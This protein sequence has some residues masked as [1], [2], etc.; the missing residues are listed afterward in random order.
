M[1]HL[2]R[3]AIFFYLLVIFVVGFT[4]LLVLA[5]AVDFKH[6]QD[7]LKFVYLDPKA[8]TIAGLVVAATMLIGFAFA[9]IIYG[10]QAQERIIHFD[11]PLGRVSISLSALEDMIRRLTVNT[12]QVKEIRPE[13]AANKKGLNIHIRLVLRSDVNIPEMTA[14][15]QD[16][17]RRKVQDLIGSEERVHIRVHVIKI[18]SDG[19]KES[20]E[21]EVVSP[22]PFRGYRA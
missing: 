13:I 16:I 12:P 8:G 17:I 10:R 2:I 22:V 5:H 14:D 19:V 6:Y 21:N 15:L 9:R 11:N 7:F 3:L 20:S 1:R 18:V 4:A